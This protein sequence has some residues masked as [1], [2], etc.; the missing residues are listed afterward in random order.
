MG[1]IID[2]NRAALAVAS[3]PDPTLKWVLDWISSKG[4]LVVGGKLREE[5]GKIEKFRRLMTRLKQSGRLEEM[6]DDEV[7]AKAANLSAQTG[8]LKSDDPHVL[9]LAIVS[10]VR[11]ICTDDTALMDDIKNKEVINGP[12]GKVFRDY[13]KHADLLINSTQ[14]ERCSKRT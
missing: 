10:G 6:D 5:L 13:R 9:A 11:V 12:R 1:V 14:C 3:P 4:C 7:N 8:L 2:A